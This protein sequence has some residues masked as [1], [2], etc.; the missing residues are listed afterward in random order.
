MY[1]KHI[2]RMR[3]NKRREQTVKE[4]IETYKDVIELLGNKPIGD[5]TKI[6]GRDYR[7]SLLKTPKNR[8]RVKRYRD[9]NIHELLSLDIPPKD[10]MSFDN[11]TKLISRMTSM[12]NFLLDEYPEHITENV[13]KSNLIRK[14]PKKRKDRRESFTDDEIRLIFNH[15]TYLPAIFV[16]PTGRDNTIQY[17]YF[18]YRYLQFLLVV[19]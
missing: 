17:P 8:K 6:D 18:L 12:W 5:Y 9:K 4:T 10:L 19:D 1:P 3:I 13:F 7:N 2:E 11:Q 14:N 16:N 15:K